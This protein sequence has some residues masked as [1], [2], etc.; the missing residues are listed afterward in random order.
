MGVLSDA[1]PLYA[2]NFLSGKSALKWLNSYLK[3]VNILFLFSLYMIILFNNEMGR[4]WN[5]SLV[6]EIQKGPK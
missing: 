1:C 4:K 6:Y 5:L 2:Q 3:S